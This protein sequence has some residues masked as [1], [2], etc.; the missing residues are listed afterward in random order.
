MFAGL[1]GLGAADGQDEAV[2]VLG[3]LVDGEGSEL[4][5]AKGGNEA[6]EEQGPVP[7]AGQV[8]FRWPLGRIPGL[9]GG[10]RSMT[11]HSSGGMSAQNLR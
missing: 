3:D 10:A 8:R 11:S 9:E 5:A 4:G 1:V 7:E 6:D 2:G